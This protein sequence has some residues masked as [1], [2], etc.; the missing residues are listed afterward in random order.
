MRFDKALMDNA[1]GL[2]RAI[3][4][5]HHARKLVGGLARWVSAA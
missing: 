5:R 3:I 1:G 4:D 2:R